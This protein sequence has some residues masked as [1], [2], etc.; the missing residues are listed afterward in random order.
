MRWLREESGLA[1]VSLPEGLAGLEE[2]RVGGTSVTV[3]FDDAYRDT[4]TVGAPILVRYGIPFTVFV[5]GSFLSRPP[6]PGRYLDAGGLR[7]LAAVPG[8]TI[9]AH[10]HTHRPLT[11]LDDRAV[12]EELRASTEALATASGSRPAALSYPHGAVD[13][14]IARLVGAAGFRAAATSLLG[15]NRPGVPPLR[16]RRTEISGGDGREVFAG[17]LRGDFDWYQLKQRLYWPLPEARSQV[18]CEDLRSTAE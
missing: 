5:V 11:R 9:G 17:K 6:V 16:L 12:A 18:R 15:L 4:L 8:A 13:A 2:G 1:I 14:R 7:E 3:T 10:G